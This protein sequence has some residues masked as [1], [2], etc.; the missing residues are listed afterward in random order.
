LR[1]TLLGYW[2][3]EHQDPWL[4]LTDLAPECAEACWYDLKAWKE[5]IFKRS[6]RSHYW[7]LLSAGG[8]VEAQANF[9]KKNASCGISLSLR[10][11]TIPTTIAR[12][13]LVS[14]ALML[15]DDPPNNSWHHIR[16]NL[17]R[18]PPDGLATVKG[19]PQLELGT[20]AFP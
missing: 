18:V 7:W 6:K 12:S 15:T 13:E 11:E 14:V 19:R 3:E 17:Y 9:A 10:L 8:E 1:C 5:Q 4:V 16:Q 20:I 2:G